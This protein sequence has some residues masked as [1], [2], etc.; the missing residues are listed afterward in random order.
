MSPSS[1]LSTGI[2]CWIGIDWADMKKH[3]M[4]S[5]SKPIPL[6][7]SNDSGSDSSPKPCK[8]GS[9]NCASVLS[10]RP[11]TIALERSRAHPAVCLHPRTRLFVLFPINPKSLA[12]YREAFYPSIAKVDT[13]DA[14]LLR[15]MV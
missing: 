9:C 12:R 3:V 15:E 10:A 8:T 4:H 2:V 7:L 11:V 1:P 5:E 14:D 6:Q 13:E